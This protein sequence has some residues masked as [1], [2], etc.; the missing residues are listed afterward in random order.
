MNV[1]PLFGFGQQGKSVT[2]T[3]QR[4]LNLYAEIQPEAE[5]GQFV[6]YGT[7]GL[8]LR[9]SLGDNPIRGWIAVGDYYYVIHLGTFYQIDNS[10]TATSRGT[11]STTTGRVDMAYDGA[12]ILLTTGTNGY[13]YTIASTTFAVIADGDFP[14]VANTCTWL[15]GQ[16][17]VDDGTADTFY[18]S[19]DGTTWGALDFATAES[20]PDGLVRVFV[21][22][23]EIIL[24]GTSTIEYWSNT[25]G[26]DFPFSPIK[27]ATSE[28]GLAA[29]W[30]LC[31]FNS[32]VAGLMKTPSGGVQ[33]CFIQ[34]Y[35]P[36]VISTQEIDSIINDYSAVSD[37]TAFSYMLGGHP[38][39]QINF[40]SVNASWLFDAST[41]LWSSVESGL[42][43]DRHRCEMSL[44]FLSKTLASD[45]E[46]GEIY[47]IDSG[48][49][50]DNGDLIA[51]EI[52]GRHLFRGNDE[53]RIYELY[54][55]METG[56]GVPSG[57][58][59]YL[60]ALELPGD[61]DDYA[62]TPDSAAV[63]ITGD[64][65]IRVLAAATDW[66]TGATQVLASKFLQTGNQ[67]SYYI[68]ILNNGRIEVAFS[69][70]GTSGTTTFQN[71]GT[72]APFTDGQAYWVRATMDIDN[73][74]GSY[75]IKYYYAAVDDYDPDTQSGTWTQL[76][77]TDTGTAIASIFDGTSTFD[78]G[79]I[80]AGTTS[81]FTG[82]IYRAQLFDGI[83]G[84]LVADCNLQDGV[85]G[86]T[87]FV[88]SETGEVYT[89]NGSAAIIAGDIPVDDPEPQGSNPQAMLSISKDNG[90]TFGAELWKSI[91]MAGDYLARVVWRRLG[92]GRD[93]V[94]KLRV[95]DPV[96]VVITYAAAR[97]R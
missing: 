65:D 96:K 94:F 3:A 10:G 91:G 77:S 67:R 9:K 61:P 26:A 97:V 63:S 36:K 35:V 54:V 70:A 16:F 13:T 38:M 40:P 57:T 76:R 88:S 15:D 29:R 19:S 75:E 28:Y 58:V 34:G 62:S 68:S 83:D 46:T 71:S 86:A 32:G 55:D 7:P 4:H 59:T 18:I 95:T 42:N 30:S 44:D 53:V 66:S 5:K 41:G 84:T 50:T 60:N 45:Y 2:V 39:Y 25:G 69:T 92:V 93:W 87:S 17:I 24:A 73:G 11:I 47:Q 82:N 89:V 64:F 81:R 48:T 90:H 74:S 72:V 56:V 49:Y 20:N 21:D 80:N 52:S 23:G 14:Q 31:K 37:A 85:I 33:V 79:A 1:I 8:L 27:G 78:I 43:G 12:V 6:F 51:R 22:N